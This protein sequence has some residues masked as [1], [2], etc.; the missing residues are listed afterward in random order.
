MN[1]LRPCGRGGTCRPSPTFLMTHP[2]GWRQSG[3]AVQ[4]HNELPPEEEDWHHFRQ[5]RQLGSPWERP[6]WAEGRR[7]YH[8][9]LTFEHAPDLQGLATRCQEPFGDLPQFDLVSLDALHLTIQRVA[10]S[11]EIPISRLPAVT[12]T[13]RQ[14]CQDVAPFRL[15]VGWLAGSAGAIRFTALPVAPVVVVRTMVTMQTAT[16]NV[17][18]D[19]PSCTPETFWPHISI[20]YSNT[21]QPATPI[22]THIEVL[23]NLPPA[24]VP[25][26]NIALVELRREDRAYR[27][28]VLERVR[29]GR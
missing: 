19:A 2:V 14:R 20:A 27:W 7:S 15:R 16:T 13:V 10:F 3:A 17:R 12:A 22:A 25:V 9:F 1:W 26:T 21:A 11:D 23:R 6:G 5:L 28:K 8:W 24:E 29:L 18:G 4:P